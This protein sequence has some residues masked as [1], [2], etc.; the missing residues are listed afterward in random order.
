[1]FLQQGL[2]RLI[3]RKLVPFGVDIQVQQDKHRDL[4]YMG[5]LTRSLAT[6]DFSSASD[7]V[8]VVLLKYLLPAPWFEAVE[9]IRCPS[10][11][12]EGEVVELSCIATMG[13]A[14]TFVLETL[15]LFSLAVAA[16]SVG[17]DK[18]RT[19]FPSWEDFQKVSVFGDDCILPVEDADLFM[20]VCKAVGFLVNMEKSFFTRDTAFRESCGADYIGGHNVR[21]VYLGGPRSNKPSNLRAWLYT[22]WNVTCK[23]LISSLGPL[24]YAYSQVLQYLA[25]LISRYNKELFLISVSDPDDA[26]IMT[27]GDEG[28]LLRL[29]T[30]SPASGMLD[31]NG[32]LK[33]RRL[34]SAPPSVGI[35]SP[36]LELW[37]RLK[38]PVYCDPF[39]V[40]R[41]SK[42]F[43]V[44]KTDRGYVVGWASSFDDAL[45]RAY[46]IIPVSPEVS[47]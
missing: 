14:T 45:R 28:R 20:S 4:A 33:Y 26:G 35:F 40:V 11:S 31:K 16:V 17:H 23:R 3:A 43:T 5:S 37:L 47:R 30:I 19:S 1:M 18:S 25:S 39:H 32:T 46:G 36:E 24:T 38:F 34:V 27:F 13:N 41:K 9:Q 2:G 12:V 6:I 15:V 29:F 22:I 44:R 10:V 21:P 8:G 7:T 42:D